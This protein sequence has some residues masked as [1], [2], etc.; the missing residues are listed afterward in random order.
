ME[1]YKILHR[2]SWH[3]MAY[4]EKKIKSVVFRAHFLLQMMLQSVEKPAT[5]QF[6]IVNTKLELEVK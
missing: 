2:M 5:I 1:T 6:Y 4:L 3:C